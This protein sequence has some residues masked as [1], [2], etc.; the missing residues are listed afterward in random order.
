MGL[1]IEKVRVE[2]WRDGMVWG[3]CA[4]VRIYNMFARHARDMLKAGGSVLV[5]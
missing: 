3:V 5:L 2:G 4:Y 1:A